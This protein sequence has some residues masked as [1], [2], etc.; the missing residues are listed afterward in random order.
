[1]SN[2]TNAAFSAM[3]AQFAPNGLFKEEMVARDYILSQIEK[4][5]SWVSSTGNSADPTTAVGT[6]S[7]IFGGPLTVRFKGAQAS[8]QKMGGLTAQDQIVQAKYVL[9]Q[10]LV[11]PETWGSLIFN[12]KDIMVHGKVSELNFLNV[13]EDNLEDFM[14]VMKYNIS[15]ALLEGPAYCKVVAII[16]H[17]TNNTGTVLVDRPDR[18]YVGQKVLINLPAS[19]AVVGAGTQPIFG[20]VKTIDMNASS[21]GQPAGSVVLTSDI[22]LSSPLDFTGVLQ[23]QTADGTP[24]VGYALNGNLPANTTKLYMDGTL[25][26]LAGVGTGSATSVINAFSNLKD[27]LFPYGKATGTSA[28][29]GSQ[30]IYGITKTLYPYT[31]AIYIDGSGATATNLVKKAFYGFTQTRRYGKGRPTD[32]IMS[33]NNLAVVM[34]IV[35]ASKGAFN[36]VPNSYKASQYG[37]TEVKIGSVTNQTLKFVGIQEMGDDWMAYI[38]WRA[39]K[40][41]S[42]GMFRKH[43]TPDG[44]EYFTTRSVTGYQY[45]VD[46]ALFG[47]I[48]LERP[49]YCGVMGDI[50]INYATAFN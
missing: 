45:I 42:N 15:T 24:L 3:L 30:T 46:I 26:G 4:D 8:S 10:I 1:M 40:F 27:L 47:D 39:L 36:V 13:L 33:Y 12:H 29:A 31:Q 49:S 41:Y 48:V 28:G 22:A 7:G 35:E 38:D 25:D 50:S 5:D 32:I 11:Q 16:N 2:A 21:G 9:G 43:K 6:G 14:N 23:R 44:V 17:T 19:E 20:F 34:A 18:L 37:F